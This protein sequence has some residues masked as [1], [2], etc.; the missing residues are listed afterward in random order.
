MA[1]MNENVVITQAN[2]E[3]EGWKRIL[4]FLQQENIHQKNKLA[5]M[6]KRN[7]GRNEYLLEIAEHYQSQFLQQDDAFRLMWND[8]STLER[9]IKK[10]MLRNHPH[11]GEVGYR[12]MM[13]RTEIRNLELNFDKLKSDFSRFSKTFA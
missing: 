3:A 1:C 9:L 8:L 4:G 7:N 12:Q 10:E 2:N 5:E 11:A 13:L 6:L